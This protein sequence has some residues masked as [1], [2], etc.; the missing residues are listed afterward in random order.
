MMEAGKVTLEV[1]RGVVNFPIAADTQGSF[2]KAFFP[3]LKRSVWRAH[4]CNVEA[5]E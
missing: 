3:A 2:L 5:L 1:G 4:A